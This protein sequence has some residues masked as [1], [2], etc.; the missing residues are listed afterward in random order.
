MALYKDPKLEAPFSRQIS[1]HKKRCHHHAHGVERQLLFK[2]RV[3]HKIQTL[4]L[5]N[6]KAVEEKEKS[7]YFARQQLIQYCI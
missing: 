7:N 3:H 4:K 1:A 6:I 5:L 2:N